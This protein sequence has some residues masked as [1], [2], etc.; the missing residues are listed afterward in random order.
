MYLKYISILL[1]TYST[2]E[3]NFLITNCCLRISL[4]SY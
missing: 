2:N 4:L 1:D 3:R